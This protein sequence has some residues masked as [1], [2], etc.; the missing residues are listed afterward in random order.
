MNPE[1]ILDL[2]IEIGKAVAAVLFILTLLTL[3][4]TL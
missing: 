3:L 4:S 1:Q 2:L